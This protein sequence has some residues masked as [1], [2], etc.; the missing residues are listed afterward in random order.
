MHFL[1]VFLTL[2]VFA[3]RKDFQKPNLSRQFA[4]G[5]GVGVISGEQCGDDPV[6]LGG[7]HVAV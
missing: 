4:E 5:F 2:G 7:D 3:A 1:P 6:A